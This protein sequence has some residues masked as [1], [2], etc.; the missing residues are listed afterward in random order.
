MNTRHYILGIFL[1]GAT[2]AATAEDTQ[3]AEPLLHARVSFASA[4]ALIKGASDADWSYATT[5][6][7]VLPG[8]TLWADNEGMLEVEFSGGTF[9]RFADASK[10]EVVAVPPSGA[11]RGLSGSFYVQRVSR[12]QGTV[13]F[14]TPVGAVEIAPNSQVRVDIVD[15]GATTLTVRWGNATVRPAGGG[16][17]MA[18]SQGLR[19]YIDPGYLPSQP[20]TFDRSVEDAFDTWNRERARLLAVGM[21]NIPILQPASKSSVYSAPPVGVSDLNSQGEWVY[22]DDYYHWRPTVIRDYVPY[23]SGYW[24]YNSLCGYTWIE[25]YPFSYVTTHYGY[26]NY[27][28]DYGWLWRYEPYWAPARCATMRYGDYFLW[29][30]INYHG[31]PV[32]HGAD[33]FSIGGL[34]FGVG[35]TSYAYANDV[36]NGYSRCH[37]YNSTT[38]G[39]IIAENVYIWNINTATSPYRDRTY[40][41]PA[42]RVRDYNPVRVMRGPSTGGR[43]SLLASERAIALE[44]RASLRPRTI[45]TAAAAPAVRTAATG[46]SRRASV[47]A[48]RLDRTAVDDTPAAIQRATRT[49]SSARRLVAERAGTLLLSNEDVSAEISRQTRGASRDERPARGESARS[50]ARESARETVST[51]PTASNAPDRAGAR[52]RTIRDGVVPKPESNAGDPNPERAESR[53]VT[54]VGDAKPSSAGVVSEP[55]PTRGAAPESDAAPRRMTIPRTSIRP[56][57]SA[58]ESPRVAQPEIA[59]ASGAED[60]ERPVA[61]RTRETAPGTEAA[62]RGVTPP[63][64][65][66]RA[67][68]SREAAPESRNPSPR[69]SSRVLDSIPAAPSREAA[70]VVRDL[71]RRE[72]APQEVAVP[73]R[74]D[75]PRPPERITRPTAPERPANERPDAGGRRE[76]ARPEMEKPSAP[77]PEVQRPTIER[78]ESRRPEMQRPEAPRSPAAG[79]QISA[80]SNPRGPERPVSPREEPSSRRT[81]P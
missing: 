33:Y 74:F 81:R 3:S 14:E 50:G 6:S 11:L 76:I 41:S 23:R 44:S 73:T 75:N 25:E 31:R 7:L 78:P 45:S 54:R 37:A 21:E 12:S 65:S 47:R 24:S 52:N 59:P 30:P 70:P 22:V 9:L 8:D 63:R 42:L 20:E 38:I 58:V 57:R 49:G 36:L 16:E 56:D 67:G 10:A 15:E 80:P 26:W 43:D 72:S 51:P 27:N 19:S 77:R 40:Q 18:I 39:P 2:G 46:E 71:P 17:A 32:V 4:S 69:S 62:P 66:R 13:I 29:S 5:N 53:R 68:P 60:I 1:L 35:F 34:N 61:T 48:V 64:E 79:P 55:R 28:R